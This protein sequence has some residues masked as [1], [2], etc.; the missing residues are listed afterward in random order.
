MTDSERL[1]W[2]EK[3]ANGCAVIHDDNAHW[4]FAT[5]GM[6]NVIMG[7]GPGN[8]KTSYFIEKSE[9]RPTIREAIDAAIAAAEAPA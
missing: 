8:L 7:D 9:F 1:D 4:A 6:Q 2:L 5:N 3:E